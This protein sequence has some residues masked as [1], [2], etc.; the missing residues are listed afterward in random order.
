MNETL[1]TIV[2]NVVDEPNRRRLE[3]GVSVTTF[4]IA[5]TARRFDRATNHWTDGDSLFLKVSCWRALAENVDRSFVKGDPVVVVGRLHTRLYEVGDS[6]RAAYELEATAA[7]FDLNRGVATFKRVSNRGATVDE[8]GVDGL[9]T[10]GAIDAHLDAAQ[11]IEDADEPVGVESAPPGVPGT[12]EPRYRDDPFGAVPPGAE[13]AEGAEGASGTESAEGG[14]AEASDQPTGVESVSDRPAAAGR[15]SVPI[16][17][18]PSSGR[19]RGATPA[20]A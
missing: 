9:P 8:V 5:S 15:A 19:R 13:G 11:L 1:T 20:L 2:G 4:R 10:G 6:R 3:S 14:A 16:P 18:P 12:D 17:R 7:G